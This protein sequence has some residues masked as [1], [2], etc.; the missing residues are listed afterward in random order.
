MKALFCE[1]PSRPLSNS[2]YCSYYGEIFYA[3]R[4]VF[5]I[6]HK[7]FVP[8]TTSEFHEYDIVFLGHGH[9]NC[10]GRKKPRP[11]TRNSDVKLFPILN[12]EY[13]NLNNKLNWIKKMQPTA[14][15]TVHHDIH[16]YTEYTGFPFHRIMWSANQTQ[17]KNYGGEYKHDLFFSGVTRPEQT[18]NLRGR[19]LSN[20]D[21][22]SN[23]KLFVNSRT[24]KTNFKGTIFSDDEYSKYL[25]SS[26]ICLITTGPADLVGTRYFEVMATNRSL[27]L[28]N[29]VGVNIY[30]DIMI[31]GHNC[32]MFSDE[33]EFF[34][35]A[36]Y[37]LENEDERMK[38][39]N[40]A[41]DHFINS[42]TWHHRAKQV[43]NIICKYVK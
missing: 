16:R 20:L 7:N 15:L 24:C 26:K 10:G 14:G 11:L 31:D 29:R 8:R 25:S 6:E 19:V 5:D 41:Y 1:H 9:T 17:F 36:T 30:E 13:S 28:C 37:Y 18:E 42:Q 35:K 34:E 12:K 43:F 40:Q 32:V 27:I 23:Y 2:G 3:L 33:D 22:L 4:E 21:R 39:V 38:I